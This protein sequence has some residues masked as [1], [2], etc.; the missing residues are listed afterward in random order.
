MYIVQKYTE[1][2]K[3]KN[4][5]EM[6]ELGLLGTHELHHKINVFTV[7]TIQINITMPTI[8]I[9]IIIII[10]KTIPRTLESRAAFCS[11]YRLVQMA[12]RTLRL[13]SRA[14]NMTVV[15]ILEVIP[16][17]LRPLVKTDSTSR[18]AA[19]HDVRTRRPNLTTPTHRNQLDSVGLVWV[20]LNV[21]INT[22]QPFYIRSLIKYYTHSRTLRSSNQLLLDCPRFSQ[23]GKR[24]FSYLAPTVWNDL[25]LDTRL[26]PTADTFKRRLKT[27]LFEQPTS[28]AHLATA[29]ASDSA[30][31]LTLYALQITILLLLLLLF[32][33]LVAD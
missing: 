9:I 20:T 32:K 24:S 18:I 13:S 19:Q 3:N 23:F 10:S 33:Q 25:P 4:T 5:H 8:I 27:V 7:K 29:G 26:S 12:W 14:L 30:L 16:Q 22:S 15:T 31:L 11:P 21:S 28:A 1:K 17:Q 6:I 2:M